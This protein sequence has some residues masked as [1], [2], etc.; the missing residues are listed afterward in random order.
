[1]AKMFVHFVAQI[2]MGAY[3]PQS[4]INVQTVHKIVNFVNRDKKIMLTR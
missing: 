1:M 3:L 4:K 2:I